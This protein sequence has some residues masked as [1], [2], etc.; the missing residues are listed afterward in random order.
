MEMSPHWIKLPSVSS[1]SFSVLA[2]WS[3]KSVL[4]R[5]SVGSQCGG[6][7][8]WSW[9]NNK[10]GLKCRING[11]NESITD[12]DTNAFSSTIIMWCF[13]VRCFCRLRPGSSAAS[14]RTVT[15]SERHSLKVLK[16]NFHPVGTVVFSHFFIFTQL[17]LTHP[18]T[19]SV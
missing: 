5:F 19:G 8:V 1:F 14:V 16:P 11:I 7:E 12:A 9:I 13:L 17:L 15:V 6:P 3:K 10:T 4:Q 18:A 2:L